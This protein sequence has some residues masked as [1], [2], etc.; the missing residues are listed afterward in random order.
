[1]NQVC[2]MTIHSVET[3]S[4]GLCKRRIWGWGTT[5]ARAVR[6]HTEPDVWRRVNEETGGR[7]E[8][9]LCVSLSRPSWM[10]VQVVHCP[11]APGFRGVVSGCSISA[12]ALLAK[13]S[14][15]VSACI[16]LKI[17]S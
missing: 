15:P 5:G 4:R 8:A 16:C 3:K 14:A 13:L 2:N 7:R 1:M 10:V 17:W 6:N 9:R 12:H 11:K